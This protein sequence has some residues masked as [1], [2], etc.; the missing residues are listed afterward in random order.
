M[1]ASASY[2]NYSGYQGASRTTTGKSTA[3]HILDPRL[4][5]VSEQLPDLFDHKRVLDIGCNDG[6]VGVDIALHFAPTLVQGIDKDP[7][8]VSKAKSHLSFRWSRLGP[9]GEID[10]FPAS[11]L[12]K[13]GHVPYPT[14]DAEVLDYDGDGEA[15]DTTADGEQ[16]ASI[17][18]GGFPHNVKF[19]RADYHDWKTELAQWDTITMLSVV[20][21][22]HLERGDEGLKN[23]F[24]KTYEA[25]SPGGYLVFEPQDWKSYGTAVK[26]NPDQKKQ[27]DAVQIRP[28]KFLELLEETGFEVVVRLEEGRKRPLYVL[29]K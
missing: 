3:S 16:E 25:L 24:L 4:L 14:D 13:E 22:L 7:I 23:V 12:E 15:M 1:P 20:K 26:K 8:L 9:N 18:H 17:G 29:R 27:K 28:E 19:I 21:W 10:Y 6:R 5:A 11:S 2:G